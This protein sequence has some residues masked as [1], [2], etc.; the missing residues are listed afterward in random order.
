MPSRFLTLPVEISQQVL[1]LAPVKDV[2]KFSGTSKHARVISIQPL[3]HMSGILD[4]IERSRSASEEP[5]IFFVHDS[6]MFCSLFAWMDYI[7]GDAS[8]M[9]PSFSFNFSAGDAAN[10]QVRQVANFL[11]G[12]KWHGKDVDIS[13]CFPSLAGSSM[14]QI[15]QKPLHT[16]LTA[17]ETIDTCSVYFS[18]LWAK[19]TRPLSFSTHTGRGKKFIHTLSFRDC[20]I[21]PMILDFVERAGSLQRLN[22][23]YCRYTEPVR[24]HLFMTRSIIFNSLRGLDADPHMGLNQILKFVERHPLLTSLRFMQANEPPRVAHRP[25]HIRPVPVLLKKVAFS[26]TVLDS[27]ISWTR[28]HSLEEV[29]IEFGGSDYERGYPYPIIPFIDWLELCPHLNKLTLSFQEAAVAILVPSPSDMRT[30][31]IKPVRTLR[32]EYSAP[33]FQFLV[34]FCSEVVERQL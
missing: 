22:F 11:G 8:R 26:P 29:R 12:L 13:F 30:G 2:L 20:T 23:R 9:P 3:V 4:E 15:N 32:L 24:S 25:L 21:T 14:V 6:E 5:Q 33:P 18:Q 19:H 1:R 16:L 34:R 31:T 17:L 7:G 27:Y 10:A 28:F